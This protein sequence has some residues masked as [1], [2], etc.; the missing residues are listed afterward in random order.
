MI[1]GLEQKNISLDKGIVR[2][3]SLGVEGELSECVNLIPHAGEMVRIHEPQPL[4]EDV[5]GQYLYYT[6]V[7]ERIEG[8]GSF[9][10]TALS[11]YEGLRYPCPMK[12]K[13]LHSTDRT[14]QT[15]NFTIATDNMVNDFEIDHLTALE[16][17]VSIELGDKDFMLSLPDIGY[18]GL[19]AYRLFEFATPQDIA[20]PTEEEQANMSLELQ[21]GELLMETNRCMDKE[22]L[23]VRNG[24][25]LVYYRPG[26]GRNVICTLEDGEVEVVTIGQTIVVTQ[27]ITKRYF[28]WRDKGYKEQDLL[29]PKAVVKASLGNSLSTI[30]QTK[31]GTIF[32]NYWN[33]YFWSGRMMEGDSGQGL[34]IKINVRKGK[35]ITWSSVTEGADNNGEELNNSFWAAYTYHRKKL[36]DENAHCFPF[37]IRYALELYDGSLVNL[38]SPILMMPSSIIRPYVGVIYDSDSYEENQWIKTQEYSW[39]IFFNPRF[40]YLTIDASTLKDIDP[41][42]IRGIAIFATP[43]IEAVDTEHFILTDAVFKYQEEPLKDALGW[44]NSYT[45]YDWGTSNSSTRGHFNY[46]KPL[47]IK[48]DVKSVVEALT[49]PV[50]FYLLDSIPWDTFIAHNYKVVATLSQGEGVYQGGF[51]M[52]MSPPDA[53]LQWIVDQGYFPH[54]I[55]GPLETLNTQKT[56]A[57]FLTAGYGYDICQAN[58]TYSY[59]SRLF[60]GGINAK[61]PIDVHISEFLAENRLP[62][63]RGGGRTNAYLRLKEGYLTLGSGDDFLEGYK[64]ETPFLAFSYTDAEGICLSTEGSNSGNLRSVSPPLFSPNGG[65]VEQSNGWAGRVILKKKDDSLG[66]YAYWSGIKEIDLILYPD[67]E[68]CFLPKNLSYDKVWTSDNYRLLSSATYKPNAIAYTKVGNPWVVEAIIELACGEIYALTSATEALSEGQFGEFPIYAFTDQGIYAL[69]LNT[70]GSVESRQP[71][72]RSILLKGCTPLQIDKAVVYPDKNGIS[73]LTGR[74]RQLLSGGISGVNISEEDFDIAEDLNIKDVKPLEE[75][76]QD[77]AQLYD[78][79]N[80]LIHVFGNQ[81]VVIDDTGLQ[82]SVADAQKE[83]FVSQEALIV[84]PNPKE[85]GYLRY[86]Y[87]YVPSDVT[88]F[89]PEITFKGMAD[90]YDG[91]M[92]FNGDGSV[93]ATESTLYTILNKGDII[94]IE[95]LCGGFASLQMLPQGLV[96]LPVGKKDLQEGQ[97]YTLEQVSSPYEATED[98]I[99]FPVGVL[100]W[101]VQHKGTI[102]TPLVY[103]TQTLYPTTEEVRRQKHYVYD[104]E[105]GQWSTQI[106]DKQLTTCVAGYPFSTMQFGRQLMQYTN[107]LEADVL[108]DGWFLTRPMSFNDPYTRKMLWDLRVMGQKTNPNTKWS[109]QVYISEDRNKWQRLTS[110]KGRSAKWYRF[111]LKASM[112]GL[113][114]LTGIACQFVPRLGNKLR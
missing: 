114:T 58:S 82:W 110:L 66:G 23:I 15:E 55:R 45:I 102:Q 93:T 62:I 105:S 43:E 16:D 38:S 81:S 46:V 26:E 27:G 24:N 88:G 48:K 49:D 22:N 89:L 44:D 73:L 54:Y 107:E 59:N 86:S 35:D 10:Y 11:G 101:T 21:P 72:S 2:T 30:S 104:L 98:C 36:K 113:D 70:D 74:S 90:T 34:P 99:V 64:G 96:L 65:S 31:T 63:K 108:R 5:T 68:P 13:Y 91:D 37:F 100:Y 60:Y 76:L 77:A 19:K 20:F 1:E 79:A 47:P 92:V 61:R 78:A 52:N 53:Y 32:G 8:Q 40:L 50:E 83:D 103:N 56:L 39:A 18:V 97:K 9:I 71:I 87:T 67:L 33:G 7:W 3:P 112:T 41:S 28:V 111:L 17:I 6:L 85:P 29:S 106:L 109:V 4:T 14:E 25:S 94:S 75:Q 57:S 84:S 80:G 42:L 12:I 69:T 95:R 51:S